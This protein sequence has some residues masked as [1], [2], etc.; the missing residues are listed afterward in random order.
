MIWGAHLERRLRIEL[1]ISHYLDIDAARRTKIRAGGQ[2]EGLSN[3]GRQ[4]PS[5]VRVG[6]YAASA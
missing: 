4:P 3:G 1:T 5:K 2:T 6:K